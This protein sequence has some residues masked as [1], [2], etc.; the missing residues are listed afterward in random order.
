MWT[1]IGLVTGYYGLLDFGTRGAIG[2]FVAR[3][4]AREATLEVAELT[5]SA[6][7]F[8]ATAGAVVLL[9]GPGSS[10]CSRT[11]SASRRRSAPRA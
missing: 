11:C 9:V 10:S 8:L 5:A 4:R 7:W 6:F 1:L 2:F 3:A